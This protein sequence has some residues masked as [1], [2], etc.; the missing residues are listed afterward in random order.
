MN[1]RVPANL[2]AG[3]QSA[4]HEFFAGLGT[5]QLR[6]VHVALLLARMLALVEDD[7][8]S[9]LAGYPVAVFEAF[10]LERVAAPIVLVVDHHHTLAV[11][12]G[13]RAREPANKYPCCRSNF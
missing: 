2:I 12:V 5:G 6:L 8:H 3:V 10:S 11:R 4:V 7:V 9:D 13:G 1:V